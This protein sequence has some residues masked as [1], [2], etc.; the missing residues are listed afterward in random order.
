MGM[1]SLMDGCQPEKIR[2]IRDKIRI[3][4][5]RYCAIDDNY[6]LRHY[7][8]TDTGDLIMIV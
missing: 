7:N 8:L 1:L 2:K 6:L 5:G 4:F 3:V